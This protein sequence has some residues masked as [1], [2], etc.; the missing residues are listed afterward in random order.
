MTAT[1]EPAGPRSSAIPS[2]F[3]WISARSTRSTES[4]S[5]GKRLL[6]RRTRSRPRPTAAAG[7]PLTPRAPAKAVSRTFPS[8]PAKPAISACR[9]PSAAPRTAI[10]S[11]KWRS[12]AADPPVRSRPRPLGKLEWSRSRRARDTGGAH[13]REE[14][15]AV[16][17]QPAAG[18]RL[19][20][21]GG[22]HAR[23][24]VR[25]RRGQLPEGRPLVSEADRARRRRGFS[26]SSGW[27]PYAPSARW[28]PAGS[29]GG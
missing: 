8:A 15:Q 11:G 18:D 19:V 9:A 24:R 3:R 10:P 26:S 28:R 27:S 16:P 22:C 13:Q 17:G 29:S 20:A 25:P 6:A 4:G 1:P 5:P 21:A 12:T 2:G 23:R 7:P 14:A